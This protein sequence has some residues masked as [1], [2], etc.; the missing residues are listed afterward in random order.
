MEGLWKDVVR[1]VK[2]T[3]G[4]RTQGVLSSATKPAEKHVPPPGAKNLVLQADEE[5]DWDLVE[6]RPAKPRQ[7]KPRVPEP[8]EEEI[9]VQPT[10]YMIGGEDGAGEED[11][12]P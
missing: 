5:T 2:V 3:A 6:R 4:R 11:G 12:A 8:A 7:P 10:N 1:E 9:L